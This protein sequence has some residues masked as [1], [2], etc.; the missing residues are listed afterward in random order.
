VQ[1]NAEAA[2]QAAQ[3]ASAQQAAALEKAGLE[4]QETHTQ[5]DLVTACRL[6]CI[7]IMHAAFT[8]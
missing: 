8:K 3:A 2:A 1:V 6:I 4:A 7:H 5:V